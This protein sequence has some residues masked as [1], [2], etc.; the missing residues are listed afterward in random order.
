M[1]GD[2]GRSLPA[3]YSLKVRAMKG[4]STGR[5]PFRLQRALRRRR[6]LPVDPADYIRGAVRGKSFVDVGGMWNINGAHAFL[7]AKEGATRSVLVDLYRTDEFDRELEASGNAVEFLYG[8]AAQSSTADA[9]GTFDIVWCFGVLYH[10]P[11]PFEILLVLRR[12][13]RERLFLETFGIPEVPGVANMAFYVPMLDAKG[14]RLW[15]ARAG[16]GDTLDRL[17]LAMPFDP[18]KGYAN[19]FWAPSP[20]CARSMLETA[21]FKVESIAPGHRPFRYIYSCVPDP[22]GPFRGG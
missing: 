15:D 17:G 22:A 10:H 12:M 14:R 1:L 8:D 11:S 18:D 9:L 19:N 13:C 5:L 3:V 7:A 2:R 4:R 20:S 6:G 16:R 21:G